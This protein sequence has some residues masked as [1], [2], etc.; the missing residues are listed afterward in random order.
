MWFSWVIIVL[1]YGLMIQLDEKSN[2]AEKVL[3]LLISA[4]GI[5]CLFQTPL[6]G[7]QAAMPL[8]DMATSTSTFGFIRTLGGTV[9]IS[10]GQAILS[11]FLRR[12]G[13]SDPWPQH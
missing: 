3:Y 1:G 6:I 2:T 7:L 12:K 9:G 4:V 5:G 10:V 13:R 11:G 8:K